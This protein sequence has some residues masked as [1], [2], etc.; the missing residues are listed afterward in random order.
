MSGSTGAFQSPAAHFGSSKSG[1]SYSGSRAGNTYAPKQSS[2]LNASP[3]S[4]ALNSGRTVTFNSTARAHPGVDRYVPQHS[5]VDRHGRPPSVASHVSR[6][7]ADTEN[8]QQPRIL[9]S[10]M[11][12]PGMVVRA[13]LHEQDYIGASGASNLTVASKFVSESNFGNVFTKVRIMIVVAA[14][15]SHYVALPLYTHNGNGLSRKSP[16]QQLEYVSIRDHRIDGPFTAQTENGSLR[17]E[18]LKPGINIID[19]RSTAHL[20]YPL[21]RKYDLPVVHQGNLTKSATSRLIHLYKQ[22]AP[23]EPQK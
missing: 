21:S 22:F 7:L 17:T 13:P 2:R 10:H 5:N 11:F 9:A 4:L 6:N 1:G 3:P 14:Y 15:K 8:V 12:V 16:A 18:F 19:P 23:A 20:T